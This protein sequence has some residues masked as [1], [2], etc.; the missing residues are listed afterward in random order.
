M[1]A[2]IDLKPRVGETF[3]HTWEWIDKDLTAATAKIQLRASPGS[4]VLLEASTANGRIQIIVTPATPTTPVVSTI[5]LLVSATDMALIAAQAAY[6]D[7]QIVESGGTV[8][9]LT[10]GDATIK[11]RYT[12]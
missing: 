10:E 11:P 1:T 4:T 12:V 5:V 9:Y 8:T 7:L 6:Y 2:T 3:T